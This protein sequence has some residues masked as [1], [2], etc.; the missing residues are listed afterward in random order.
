MKTGS[1]INETYAAAAFSKQSIVFDQLYGDDEI[2]RYKRERVRAH[3][4]R[5]LSSSGKLL[6]LNC[7]TGE[8]AL[9]F[10]QNGF[11][12]HA[13]DISEA[14]LEVVNAKL[15]LLGDLRV[16]T[17]QCSFTQLDQLREQGPFDAVYSNFGGLN[18]TG[19]LASVLGSLKPLVRPG[20]TVTLVIISPFCLWETLLFFKGKFT[21]AFRRFFSGSGRRAHVEG[22]YF[23]CWY[24]TPRFVRKQ[25]GDAFEEIS[26]EGLCSLVPPSYIDGFAKKY[27]GLFRFLRKK[28]DRLKCAWPWKAMGDYFI[29]SFKRKG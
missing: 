21:T 4:L 16:G 17:E 1:H 15:S 2:I 29:I 28:E 18:C 12:V 9:F 14:M 22:V 19:E 13:T 6:E 10:A 5:L 26:T 11:S 7:G 24:Y 20:G 23:N 25:M 3:M 27:P 8:D